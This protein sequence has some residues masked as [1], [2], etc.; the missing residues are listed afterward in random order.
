MSCDPPT[1]CEKHLKCKSPKRVACKYGSLTNNQLGRRQCRQCL[2]T[3]CSVQCCQ[4]ICKHTQCISTKPRGCSKTRQMR[5]KIPTIANCSLASWPWLMLGAGCFYQNQLVS[6]RCS[7]LQLGW[8]ERGPC[9]QCRACHRGRPRRTQHGPAAQYSH[10]HCPVELATNLWRSFHN[11]REGPYQ[12]LHLVESA[13]LC[14][15]I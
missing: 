10:S 4:Q 14:F 5:C 15:R 3:V 12:G 7:W 8:A 11:H 2:H 1:F 6:G 9:W 13:Y